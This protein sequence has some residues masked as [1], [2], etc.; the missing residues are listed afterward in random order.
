MAQ[1]T[2]SFEAQEYRPV[3]KW[4][5]S[6]S[7][8]SRGAFRFFRLDDDTVRLSLRRFHPGGPVDL[9]IV[10]G[11]IDWRHGAVKT[12]T[13]PS[14]S[15]VSPPRVSRAEWRGERGLAFTAYFPQLSDEGDY[16][17]KSG[18]QWLK[19]VTHFF[20][21][22]ASDEPVAMATGSLAEPLGWMDDCMIERLAKLGLDMANERRQAT[23]PEALDME[24][25][26]KRMSRRFPFDALARNY[27]G[28]VPM[29]LVVDEDGKVSHYP[30]FASIARAATA[31]CSL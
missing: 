23:Q 19:D 6:R 25:W 28:P 14:S 30:A 7:P 2:V 24:T 10:G 13:L 21:A 29:R 5:Y 16:E 26:A 8:E 3:D 1:D 17:G 27:E 18:R 22:D 11:P 4:R 15:I 31:R 12:G 9:M 20:V